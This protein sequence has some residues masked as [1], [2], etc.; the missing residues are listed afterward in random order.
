MTRKDDDH[1]TRRNVQSV[2]RALRILEVIAQRGE[3]M[4]VTDIGARSGLR[5]GTVHR[6]LNTMMSKGFIQQDVATSKYKLGVKLF[7]IGN[8]ALYD[9]D[10][11]TVSNPH[12]KRLVEKCNETAN[13]SILDEGE[14]VYIDQVESN[15]MIIVRMFARI[16]SRGPAHC[17]ASGKVLLAGLSDEQLSK[18]LKDPLERFT[19]ETITDVATL[20]K[21]IER[22]RAQG[23]ALDL[24]ERDEGVRCVAAPIRNH[25]GKVIAAISIS[26]P[27]T[28]LT[29]HYL[30]YEVL[31]LVVR[32]AREISVELGYSGAWSDESGTGLS[33]PLPHLAAQGK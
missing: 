13:L 23:Y 9:L 14:V 12:L 17:T 16:G 15:N 31:P 32:E 11:R 18:L 8:A 2:E 30:M 10:V 27:A 28:R 33:G 22:I 1:K 29:N 6:L 4:S 21:E 19:N 3:P 20:K 25:E 7:N 24:G 26:G 5:L